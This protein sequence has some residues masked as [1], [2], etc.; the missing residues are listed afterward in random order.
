MALPCCHLTLC[1]LYPL[2]CDG[3][4]LPHLDICR[5][6][7]GTLCRAFRHIFQEGHYIEVLLSCSTPPW[8][9]GAQRAFVWWKVL[10]R[11][12]CM[13][14]PLLCDKYVFLWVPMTQYIL[15]RD[16]STRTWF[17]ETYHRNPGQTHLHSKRRQLY[18]GQWLGHMQS[19]KTQKNISDEILHQI[20]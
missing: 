1:H 16:I 5:Q 19:L 18:Q 17:R 9:P 13:L 4:D 20:A 6:A 10:P 2:L 15:H 12:F 14:G 8:D 11:L 3:R 7:S